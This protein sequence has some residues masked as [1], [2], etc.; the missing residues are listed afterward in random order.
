MKPM[1]AK[2]RTVLFCLLLLSG[3]GPAAKEKSHDFFTSGSHEADQRADQRMA[4]TEQLRGSG[5]G[6]GEKASAKVTAEGKTVVKADELKSL[7]DRLGGEKSITAIV[8]D[9]VPRALADPRVNWERKGVK[10]GG[11]T[12]HRGK[13]MQ[14]N[15]SPENVAQLKKHIV[16]FISLSTGGPAYY[17]GRE[18]KE[19]HENRHISNA[20]FDAAIGDL[21]ASLDKLQVPNKEQKELLA[22]VESTRPQ[23]VQDR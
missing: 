9:F 10:M 22:I 23:V 8:E 11:F 14:W 6:G 13:L 15:A 2:P 12:V 1:L 5:E 3:C 16:Q 21:K 18:M 20:E 17:D 7:Y 19:A 4:K